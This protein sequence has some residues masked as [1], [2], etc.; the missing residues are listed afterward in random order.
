[1]KGKRG[2]SRLRYCLTLLREFNQSVVWIL[3]GKA[4]FNSTRWGFI[5]C[6]EVDIAEKTKLHK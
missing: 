2:S 4:R 3:S 1:M 6:F 5:S